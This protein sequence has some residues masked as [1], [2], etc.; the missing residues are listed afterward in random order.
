MRNENQVKKHEQIAMTIHSRGEKIIAP[1]EF[2][3]NEIK[4]SQI[5]GTTN[6]SFFKKR[7]HFFGGSSFDLF[8]IAEH[9]QNKFILLTEQ[10]IKTLEIP[11]PQQHNSYGNYLY[12]GII[13]G[14]HIF[15]F[16]GSS[17]VKP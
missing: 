6:Y 5:Q 9:F 15:E 11:Y 8:S 14:M 10:D 13:E 7:G 12:N 16:K 17:P 4:Y 1:L 2:I 3:F